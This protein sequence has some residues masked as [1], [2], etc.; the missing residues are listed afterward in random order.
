M[1]ELSPSSLPKATRSS[2]SLAFFFFR[3]AVFFIPASFAIKFF[4]GLPEIIWLDPCLFIGLVALLFYLVE[5]KTLPNSR[6]IGIGFLLVVIYFLSSFL[7]TMFAPSWFPE[8]A[9]TVQ[10]LL[11]EP[12]KV[13]L[14][15]IFFTLTF[16]YARDPNHRKTIVYWLGWSALLQLGLAVYLVAATYQPLP[17][18]AS[19]AE[20]TQNYAA[21][22]SL[23]FGD[24]RV[25][26]LAGTFFESPPFGLFMFAVFLVTFY[27]ATTSRSKQLYFFASVAFLGVLGSL[28]TQVLGGILAWGA[29]AVLGLL[30]LKPKSITRWLGN[31][32]VVIGAVL[33]LVPVIAYLIYSISSRIAIVERYLNHPE[34]LFASSFGERFFH[35]FNVFDVV[36]QNLLN[37]LLG[38]GSRYGFYVH[39]A[40]PVYPD[41]T[42][43]QV[44]PVDV[45][46]ATGLIGLVLFVVW[47]LLMLKPLFFLPKLQGIAVWIGLVAAIST[48]ATWKWTAF[49]FALAYFVGKSQTVDSG[50]EKN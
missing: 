41:T 33:A 6:I 7:N 13:M 27:E 1:I 23:W 29:V 32:A 22:Q 2:F 37:L 10:L 46:S 45:L 14:N 16:I 42:T 28:S 20:Y 9:Y 18:P 31:S 24:L 25:T 21:R 47:L 4:I 30:N 36:S 38:V 15:M 48:Q 39:Q 43:P 3:L 19:F 49:F 5:N 12:I 40:F 11:A 44:V 34:R 50:L 17:L 8:E 26:R 35:I